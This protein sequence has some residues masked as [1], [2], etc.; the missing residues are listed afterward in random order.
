MKKLGREWNQLETF[1]LIFKLCGFVLT[2]LEQERF[3]KRDQNC[4][5]K[6]LHSN[7]TWIP[8]FW[9]TSTSYHHS[10]RIRLWRDSLTERN[11]FR[12]DFYHWRDSFLK[13]YFF[14]EGI[15]HKRHSFIK[16]FISDGINSEG[17]HFW[18]NLSLKGFIFNGIHFWWDL[19]LKGFISVQFFINE[20][21]HK[22]ILS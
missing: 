19:F 4:N 10:F 5:L 16:G 17:I 20:S 9:C 11:Y 12:R 1:C 7:T 13:V 18:R 14:S 8:I 2:F 22:W 15:Y 21:I 6:I 3:F